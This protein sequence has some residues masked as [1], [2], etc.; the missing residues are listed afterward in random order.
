MTRR[1]PRRRCLVC[2]GTLERWR[3]FFCRAC[4]GR[5]PGHDRD[6]IVAAREAKDY[7]RAARLAADAAAAIER[8]SPAAIAARQLGES[9]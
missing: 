7:S 3:G 9:L 4:W 6:A 5:V 2:R 1:S 8:N